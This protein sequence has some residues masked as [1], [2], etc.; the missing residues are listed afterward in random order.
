MEILNSS[1]FELDFKR[2]TDMTRRPD[3]SDKLGGLIE[4]Y[5]KYPRTMPKSETSINNMFP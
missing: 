5:V 3:W 1:Y 2:N 4:A